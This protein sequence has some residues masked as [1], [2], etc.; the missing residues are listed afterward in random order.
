M[1]LSFKLFLGHRRIK[2]MVQARVDDVFPPAPEPDALPEERI[3]RTS[4]VAI[5]QQD[6]GKERRPP[7]QFRLPA[8][9]HDAMRDRVLPGKD[10]RMRRLRWDARSEYFLKKRSLASEARLCSDWWGAHTRSSPSG[11][12]AENRR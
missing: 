10:G 9:R 5:F 1:A 3:H 8:M 7:A 11:W 2:E 6:L 4:G 12:R